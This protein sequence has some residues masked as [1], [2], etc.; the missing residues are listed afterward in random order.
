MTN[1][2]NKRVTGIG[3]IFFKTKNSAKL[4]E[5]YHKHL[6]IEPAD[7]GT[8]RFEWCELEHSEHQGYTI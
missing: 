3:E 1:Q 6:G 7:D 5:W 8:V 4:K 2:L